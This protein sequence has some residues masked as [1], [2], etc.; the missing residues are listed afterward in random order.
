[1]VN[2]YYLGIASGDE[3]VTIDLDEPMWVTVYAEWMRRPAT[4]ALMRKADDAPIL[5]VI[6]SPGDQP[7]YTARHV[8]VAGSG[9]SNEI[10]AYGIGA[11]RSAGHTDRMW[12]MPNGVVCSGED[13]YELGVRFVKALGPREVPGEGVEPSTTA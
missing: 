4:W 13:V 9:G 7:Y 11:K 10:I 12:V 1:M 8:G 2:P 5:T 6:V 3:G